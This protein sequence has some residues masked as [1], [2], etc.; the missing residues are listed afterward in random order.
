M[1]VEQLSGREAMRAEVAAAIESGSSI[2]EIAAKV[3]SHFDMNH[4]R[5]VAIAREE[6]AAAMKGKRP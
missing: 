2:D 1:N 3:R 5:H 4:D 6:I